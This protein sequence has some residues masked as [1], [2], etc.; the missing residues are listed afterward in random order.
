MEFE[1][2]YGSY[3]SV[4]GTVECTLAEAGYY[5]DSTASFARTDCDAGY[6]CREGTVSPTPCPMGQK[7]DLNAQ[8]LTDCY[9]VPIGEYR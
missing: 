6:Y 2:A 7:S 5:V 8:Q 3:A 1:C 9:D 4:A